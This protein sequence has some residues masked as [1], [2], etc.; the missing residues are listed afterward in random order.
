METGG[1][2]VKYQKV[3]G[4]LAKS[5]NFNSISDLLNLVNC[6]EN[7]RKIRKM[8]TQFCGFRCEIYYNFCYS[9]LS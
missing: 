9:C 4:A 8:Q 3:S 2:S 7:S 6:I 1:I 5:C